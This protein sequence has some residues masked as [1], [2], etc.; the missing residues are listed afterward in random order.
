[1]FKK[2]D[3]LINQNLG[4]E[5]LIESEQNYTEKVRLTQCF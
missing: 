3:G 2:S 4:I 5:S 1:M